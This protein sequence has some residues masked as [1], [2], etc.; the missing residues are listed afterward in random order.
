MLAATWIHS[1]TLEL[2][3]GTPQRLGQLPD[4]VQV[5]AAPSYGQKHPKKATPFGLIDGITV[6]E[7]GQQELFDFL[8]AP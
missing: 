3:Q 6:K 2:A 4:D 7:L 5:H 8:L 1:S